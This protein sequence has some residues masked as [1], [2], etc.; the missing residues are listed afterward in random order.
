MPSKPARRRSERRRLPRAEAR[1]SMRVEGVHEGSSAQ[2]VTES[3][4]ISASGVYCTSSHFLAPLVEGAADHRAPPSARA[5]GA[6]TGEVRGHRRALRRGRAPWPIQFRAGVHVLRSR[7][8]PSRPDRG[9]RDLAQPPVAPCS[10]ARRRWAASHLADL[11]RGAG[12]LGR[13]ASGGQ[14]G[15]EQPQHGGTARDGH[16]ESAPRRFRPGLIPPIQVLRLTSRAAPGFGGRFQ[17]PGDKSITHRAYLIGLLHQAPI[18]IEH[19]NPGADCLASLACVRALG[20]RA[21]PGAVHGVGPRL[22]DPRRTLDCGNSGTTL[23]L[24]AGIAAGQPFASTLAGDASLNRRPVGR[25]VEPLRAMGADIHA[26]AGDRQPPLTVRGGALRGIEHRAPVASAQVLSCVVLAGLFARGTTAVELPGPARDHTERMLGS[27]G[28]PLD[29]EPR[30]GGGRRVAV[31]GPHELAA[32]PRH[33][34]I[35]GDFSAAA[36]FLAAAAGCPGARV[37]AVEVGLNPTRTGL[38]DVL[39]RMGAR[40]TRSPVREEHGE[41]I[42]DVTVEGTD[43]LRAVEV[44]AEDLPRWIDE[45]PAWIVAAAVA[46]GTS[47]ISG[48]SELRVKES[49]RIS[50]LASGLASVGISVR[51]SPDGLEIVGGRP[52]GGRVDARGDHRVAMA[53]AVLGLHARS[54]IRV[55]DVAAIETSFPGFAGTFAELGGNLTL[56]EDDAA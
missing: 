22:E 35:P 17:P 20:A 27:L 24:L 2:V 56:A 13:W 34:R 3:Q 26:A 38:L 47:R 15:R 28:V 31:T 42:G 23:R 14:A 52:Q 21:E 54:P 33:W 51:E 50:A 12:G 19:A 43:D 7:R 40:I 32:R 45:V 48:A 5:G 37:T 16:A 1:L 49:D 18:T 29:I 25:I 53:F 4:N 41:P 44:A 9:V 8:A 11:A 10:G 36:F 55:D 30:A 39:E 6:G 46:R